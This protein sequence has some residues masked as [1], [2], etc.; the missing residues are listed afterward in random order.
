MRCE[1]A[2]LAAE[3]KAAERDLERLSRHR[4]TVLFQGDLAKV[5]A[6]TRLFHQRFEAELDPQK[7]LT[8]N[9]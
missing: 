2:W 9:F 5:D 8:L 4:L 6:L 1:K 3:R 7:F